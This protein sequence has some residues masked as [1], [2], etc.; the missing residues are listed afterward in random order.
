MKGASIAVVFG[1]VMIVIGLTPG[2]WRDLVEEL[3]TGI[4]YFSD[5]L[6]GIPPYG[7]LTSHSNRER[8]PLLMLLG[9]ALILLGTLNFLSA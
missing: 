6:R 9:I 5:S 8:Q 7:P 1:A 3:S 4:R 2:L